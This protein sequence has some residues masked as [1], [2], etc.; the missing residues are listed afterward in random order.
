M[1][2]KIALLTTA[3]L[4]TA[5]S[6]KGTGPYSYPGYY[7]PAQYQNAYMTEG[8]MDA[9]GNYHPPVQVGGQYLPGRWY[10][11]QPSNPGPIPQKVYARENPYAT[12][13]GETNKISANG[14]VATS[15]TCYNAEGC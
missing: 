13:M 1:K 14:D 15:T 2:N 10:R 6:G 11:A 7:Q 12:R 4:L 8:A 5:C 9:L 3:I